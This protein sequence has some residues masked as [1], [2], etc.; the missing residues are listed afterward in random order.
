MYW[1][2]NWSPLF[3]F[4]NIS[5]PNILVLCD[6]YDTPLLHLP[7]LPSPLI[8][9]ARLLW[10]G[11]ILAGTQLILPHFCWVFLLSCLV[12]VCCVAFIHRY[13]F[14]NAAR[15]LSD[16]PCVLIDLGMNTL[17][18][19]CLSRRRW[20][21]LTE[22]A[23][24]VKSYISP[25]F[26][27][28]TCRGEVADEESNLI[29]CSCTR[30]TRRS[31]KGPGWARPYRTWTLGSTWGSV[32]SISFA[33]TR[34]ISNDHDNHRLMMIKIGMFCEC[35]PRSTASCL[36]ANLNSLKRSMG[37]LETIEPFG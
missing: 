8:C 21:Y 36:P 13:A 3:S 20:A 33:R 5:V 14:L 31:Q 30:I 28:W 37:V 26:I 6:D 19:R 23:T 22:A 1:S 32:N 24:V 35:A 25:L 9:V 12:F 2:D 34:H 11:M 10:S 29:T 7:P 18:V 27:V 15:R 16:C 17:A 4:A